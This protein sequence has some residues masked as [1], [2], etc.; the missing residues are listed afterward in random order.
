MFRTTHDARTVADRHRI[1]SRRPL[2]NHP[3]IASTRYSV[4]GR[5][6]EGGGPAAT[7]AGPRVP[8]SSERHIRISQHCFSRAQIAL[9]LEKTPQLGLA[10]GAITDV[11]EPARLP[12]LRRQ[13]EVRCVQPLLVRAAAA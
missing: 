11:T 5:R 6:S 4:Q 7:S 3:S 12:V 1:T 2:S 9:D 8:R 13:F 10:I